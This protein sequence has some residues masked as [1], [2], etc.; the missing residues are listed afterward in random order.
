MQ[1]MF[2][3]E[4]SA[5]IYLL[6]AGIFDISLFLEYIGYPANDYNTQILTYCYLIFYRFHIFYGFPYS[7][8]HPFLWSFC[9]PT[10][11]N[12]EFELEYRKL[13]K[14]YI[15]KIFPAIIQESMKCQ[16]NTSIV[17]LLWKLIT[18]WTKLLCSFVLSNNEKPIIEKNTT[19]AFRW[20]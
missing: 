3:Y 11:T 9:N 15:I 5:D 7:I 20:L 8:F 12:Y 19:K 16:I 4:L 2:L 14:K 18:V 1:V 10:D 6:V 17:V 13:T